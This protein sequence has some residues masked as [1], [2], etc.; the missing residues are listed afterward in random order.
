ML[1]RLISSGCRTLITL[2]ENVKQ[3]G[4]GLEVLD[5]INRRHR[6]ILVHNVTLP[7]CYVEHGDVTK[8]RAGLRI[9]SDSIIFDLR[10][11]GVIH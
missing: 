5:Y 2:E 1:D 9:D 4:F 7:D 3:G 8:L 6:G 10:K 11:E